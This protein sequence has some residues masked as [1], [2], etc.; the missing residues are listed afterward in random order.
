MD[1]TKVTFSLTCKNTNNK[2]VHPLRAAAANGMES[3]FVSVWTGS[4]YRVSGACVN[5]HAGRCL[6]MSALICAGDQSV[7]K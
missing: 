7:P 3:P 2:T 4:H 1:T 5:C 6:P